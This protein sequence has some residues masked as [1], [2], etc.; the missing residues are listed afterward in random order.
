MNINEDLKNRIKFKIAMLEINKEEKNNMKKTYFNKKPIIAACTFLTLSTGVVFAKDIE[1]FIK[2]NFGLGSGIDTA[3]ENGYIETPEMDYLPSKALN[4]NIEHTE[5]D[6]II[7]TDINSNIKIDDFL[8]DDYNLSIDFSIIMDNDIKKNIDISIDNNVKIIFPD[9][10]I[11]DENSNILYTDCDKNRFNEFCNEKSLNYK[12]HAFNEK[13][14]NNGLN[15]Y[16]NYVD[17]FENKYTIS[18]KYN[19][20]TSTRFPKSK[21]IILN[22]NKIRIEKTSETGTNEDR[23]IYTTLGNWNIELDVPEIMYNRSAKHYKVINCSN[24]NFDI[25]TAKVSDTG[26]EIGITLNNTPRPT[27]PDELYDKRTELPELAY[28]FNTKEEMLSISNDKNFEKMYIEYYKQLNPVQVS[29]NLPLY[30][31]NWLE[32]MDGSWVENSNGEKFYCT[33]NPARKQN[34]NFINDTTFDFYE[35]F[36]MTKSDATD[37]LTFILN[38]YGEHHKIELEKIK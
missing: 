34:R 35:T 23:I 31:I 2:N 28:R 1:N 26:F 36:G 18:T 19:I 27:I 29:N 33:L 4:N 21:K 10:I 8:M 7:L 6:G 20:Y 9:L 32:Y 37:K 11:T 3:V 17:E 24:N 12:Y 25:Y 30:G 15:S 5:N 38:Y 16:I 13:Y 14:M 22:F